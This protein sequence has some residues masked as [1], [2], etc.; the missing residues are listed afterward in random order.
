MWKTLLQMEFSEAQKQK[1]SLQKLQKIDHH[2][3]KKTNEK[4]L[5]SLEA[6]MVP[7]S[8]LQCQDQS[9]K[10]LC[11]NIYQQARGHQKK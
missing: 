7:L 4:G 9:H 10:L 5:S 8:L 3:K 2:K 1:S 6:K 11:D